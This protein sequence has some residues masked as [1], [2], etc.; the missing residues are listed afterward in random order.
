MID[1]FRRD[2]RNAIPSVQ[3]QSK[4]SVHSPGLSPRMVLPDVKHELPS[5]L[6]TAPPI[7]APSLTCMFSEQF[8]SGG[9][10]TSSNDPP[11]SAS[12]PE[13]SLSTHIS[14]LPLNPCSVTTWPETFRYLHLPGFRYIFQG[15]PEIPH[16]LLVPLK[17][18]HPLEIEHLLVANSQG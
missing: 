18:R 9:R 14:S 2:P 17:P 12:I 8:P 15:P 16:L 7:P 4:P 3:M 6:L 1:Q 11:P 10:T 13:C 5:L